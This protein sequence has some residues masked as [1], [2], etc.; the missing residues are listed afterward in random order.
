M[1]KLDLVLLFSACFREKLDDL[2]LNT[3][4][5]D[6][7]INSSQALRLYSFNTSVV[8]FTYSVNR[9]GMKIQMFD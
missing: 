4:T 5:V 2:E 1:G 3:Y 9:A 6:I 8:R 7:S